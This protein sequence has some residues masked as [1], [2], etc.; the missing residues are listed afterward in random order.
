MAVFWFFTDKKWHCSCYKRGQSHHCVHHMMA[1][2]WI[3]QESPEYLANCDTHTEE[4]EDMESETLET[5]EP[6][7]PST[8]NY[9][10]VCIMTG[11]I[12]MCQ[13]SNECTI[14]GNT[15]G[16]VKQREATTFMPHLNQGKVSILPWTNT[17][18]SSSRHPN[19][20]SPCLWIH[21][22]SK[23]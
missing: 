2:W 18:R 15:I 3:F 19:N 14:T 20:T 17:T 8:L 11:Y 13:N 21:I 6:S 5:D 1:I 10:E 16:I 4:I 23:R 7:M 22:H 9:Q 12:N